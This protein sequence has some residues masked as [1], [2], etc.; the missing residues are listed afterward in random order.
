MRQRVVLAFGLVWRALVRPG[1]AV[2]LLALA[3]SMRAR[4]WFRAPPFLPLPPRDYL[5]W[6]MYTAFGDEDALPSVRQVVRYARWRR[7]VLRP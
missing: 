3:W 1:V 5:R 2:D 6:R 7:E 4:D